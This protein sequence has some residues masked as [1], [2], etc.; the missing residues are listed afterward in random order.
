MRT[1]LFA[2]LVVVTSPLIILAQTHPSPPTTEPDVS[3]PQSQITALKAENQQLRQ[4]LD[5]A[6]AQIKDLKNQL[7][8]VNRDDIFV[9]EPEA[10]MIAFI[11]GHGGG[12]AVL[13]DTG[14]FKR[15]RVTFI[16]GVAYDRI[17]RHGNEIEPA[18]VVRKIVTI[19]GGKIS[20]ILPAAD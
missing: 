7:D 19:E 20:T 11:K 12:L 6:L 13:T 8:D 14:T 16:Q 10:D 1:T 2:V 17:T 3:D 4:Q 18:V 15:C 9:G 5:A